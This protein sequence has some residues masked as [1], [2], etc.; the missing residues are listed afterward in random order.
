M[1]S[2]QYDHRQCSVRDIARIPLVLTLATVASASAALAEEPAV[3]PS[4]IPYYDKT[5][6][7]TRADIATYLAA[8][9][10]KALAINP[11]GGIYWWASAAYPADAPRRALENCE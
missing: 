5:S 2:R 9:S 1:N 8:K 10:P 7:G 6:D 3:D 11:A 4:Q